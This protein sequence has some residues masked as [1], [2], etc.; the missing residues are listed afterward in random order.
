ML[1]DQALTCLAP[2]V[3]K[4]FQL[5]GDDPAG[6]ITLQVTT[7]LTNPS[8]FGVQIGDLE[9]ALSYKGMYLGPASATALNVTA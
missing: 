2:F 1:V 4:D 8:P 9:L 6:G 5:P 3:L 7:S